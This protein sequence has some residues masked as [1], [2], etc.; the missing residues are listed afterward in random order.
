MEVRY[1]V[2]TSDEARNAIVAFVKKQGHATN[3]NDITAVEVT[4]PSESPSAIVRLQPSLADKPVVLT[5]QYLVAALLVYCMEHRIPVPKQASKKVELTVN[6]LTMTMTTDLNQGSPLLASNQVT[7][8]EI[9]NRATERIETV[10]EQLGRAHARANH[11]ES[12]V[13]QADERV[14][15]VEAARARSAAL[16]VDIALVPGLRG[17][18]GRWLVRFSPS[19]LNERASTAGT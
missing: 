13:A 12:L 8:G 18:L 6:G 10:Q 3:S 7:Y 1:I 5:A 15:Q 2:F 14:R 11:A 17:R 9:A 19:A 4:G 16:L